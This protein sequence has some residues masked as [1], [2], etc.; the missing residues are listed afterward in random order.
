MKGSDHALHRG[1]IKNVGGKIADLKIDFF[2]TL[3]HL[4][5][6]VRVDIAIAVA[7]RTGFAVP[8]A[9]SCRQF[10]DFDK[11]LHELI[12]RV[13][14]KHPVGAGPVLNAAADAVL[15]LLRAGG[16]A[17]GKGAGCACYTAYS[18]KIVILNPLLWTQ[19]DSSGLLWKHRYLSICRGACQTKIRSSCV[20]AFMVRPL[21]GAGRPS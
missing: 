21:P 11:P 16:K 3:V 10:I 5:V 6:E 4:V 8:G 2:L 7:V 14:V 18:E 1:F 15:R 9:E 13:D 19:G 17:Q 20:A 12:A